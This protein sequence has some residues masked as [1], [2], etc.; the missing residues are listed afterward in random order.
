MGPSAAA[1]RTR[2]AII[3]TERRRRQQSNRQ[4]ATATTTSSTT[5]STL[6]ERHQHHR[7]GARAREPRRAVKFKRRHDPVATQVLEGQASS[8]HFCSVAPTD[9]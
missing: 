4:T 1:T 3:T 8:K 9:L 6:I 5:T 7:P 2:T